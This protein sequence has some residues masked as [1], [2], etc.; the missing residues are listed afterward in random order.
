MLQPSRIHHRKEDSFAKFRQWEFCI[1]NADVLQSALAKLG[2]FLGILIVFLYLWKLEF[3]PSG[4]SLT[5]G[6]TFI[7]AFLAFSF[8]V[9]IGLI[10]GAVCTY[11]LSFLI[12]KFSNKKSKL[13]LPNF[14]QSGWMAFFSFCM[15]LYMVALISTKNSN[16]NVM[17]FFIILAALG[18]LYTILALIINVKEKN[19]ATRNIYY[20][21]AFFVICILLMIFS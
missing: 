10:Y 11:W 20:V 7:F 12:A 15:F 8:L 6:I 14:A 21:M 16:N 9:I 17:E 5:D 2:L 3:M 19:K 1:K 4:L 13:K 18:Y